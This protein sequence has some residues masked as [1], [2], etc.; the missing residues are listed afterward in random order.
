MTLRP[1]PKSEE[2][3]TQVESSIPVVSEEKTIQVESSIPVV[4]EEKTIQVESSIPVVSEETSQRE[5]KRSLQRISS[6]GRIHVSRK[7][8]FIRFTIIS[9]L[10]GI[11]SYNIIFGAMKG[12]PLIVYSSIMLVHAVLNL[13]V[14]WF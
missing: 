4:S 12:N 14:G 5:G 2:K 10:I 9:L 1:F 6:S 8:W 3:T 13:A 7:G 11:T